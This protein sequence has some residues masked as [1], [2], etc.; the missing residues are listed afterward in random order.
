MILHKSTKL[1]NDS[2]LAASQGLSIKPEFIEKDYWITFVL[3][4][5]SQSNYSDKAVFKGGT[6]L[7]KGYGLIDR[8]SEDVDI[9]IMNQDGLSGNQ[10]KELIRDVEKSM[11]EDLT[12][13][14]IEGVTSKGSRFR[15]SAFEYPKSNHSLSTNRIITEVNSFANPYPYG[16]LEIKSFIT[17][18]F[19]NIDRV[20]LIKEYGMKPFTLNVLDKR[21]TLLEKLVSL[22][23]FSFDEYPTKAIASKIRHFYD[24]YFLLSDS[25]CLSFV[26]SDD[27]KLQFDNLIQHDKEAFDIPPGWSSKSLCESVLVS[28]FDSIWKEIKDI[29]TK[30]LSSLAFS[31]IPKEEQV[32][33]VVRLLFDR[34]IR[35]TI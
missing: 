27:F 9:A 13:V 21:Q 8:F 11:T 4:Q 12:E 14:E 17:K 35:T 26:Q 20:D 19:L 18:F 30:E 1:F 7:S 25:E 29:Y 15:K 3:H 23:R 16:E 24:L 28:D 5:L 33:L 31:D 2:I 34:I 32:S 10:V 22:I 6:S